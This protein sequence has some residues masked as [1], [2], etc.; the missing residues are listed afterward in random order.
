MPLDQPIR[1]PVPETG[2]LGSA[3]TVVLTTLSR[4]MLMS[5]Y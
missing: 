5:P 4:H 1:L 2:F 3:E